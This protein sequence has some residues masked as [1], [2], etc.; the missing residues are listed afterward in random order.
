MTSDLEVDGDDLVGVVKRILDEH[1]HYQNELQVYSSFT[2]CSI[3]FFCTLNCNR[4][5]NLQTSK[6]PLESQAQGTSL[7]VSTDSYARIWIFI[8]LFSS[9]DFLVAIDPCCPT[10]LHCGHKRM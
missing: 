7:F 5:H 6:A 8:N 4:N 1:T 10:I 2:R 9:P 3:S